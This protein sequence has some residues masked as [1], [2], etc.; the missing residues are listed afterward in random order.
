MIIAIDFDGTI[1]EDSY[2]EIG[3][4]RKELFAIL[5][6]LQNDG[7]ELILWTC[8][9]GDK[10]NEAVKFCNDNGLY[11]SKINENSD[12]II[13]TGWNPRKIVADIYIDDRSLNI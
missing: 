12:S 4:L 13:K 9:M 8:R 10:L 11:F 1:T 6:K 2:P 5:L 7:H 3:E